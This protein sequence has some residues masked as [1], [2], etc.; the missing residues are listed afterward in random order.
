MNTNYV[1]SPLNYVGG[2]YKLLPQIAPLFPKEIDTF[3]DL[4]GGGG[5]ITANVDAKLI[6]YNEKQREVMELI[7]YLYGHEAEYA[8]AELDGIIAEYGLSKTNKDGYLAL[9]DDYNSGYRAEMRFYALITHAF[10]YSIRFN[11]KGEFNI[12]FGANRSSFNP[13]LRE[14]FVSFTESLH[15]RTI[16]FLNDDFRNVDL[17]H[18]T[19]NDFVYIDPPY[20]ITV[21]NY[22]EQG[23]WNEQD[24]RD[25]L[26]LLDVLNGRGVKWALSNVLTHKGKVNAILTQWSEKYNVVD[27]TAS[28]ANCN[29][30]SARGESREVLITNYKTEEQRND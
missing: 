20:L 17:T 3:V 23:G 25:L 8:L 24:E 19:E 28:Y 9:R 18:L 13:K 26:A 10:N 2:K 29:Y 27:L 22:N 30:Q 15:N 6:V 11:R 14:N 21:A 5:N 1:K 12:A 16:K 4:F 7:A